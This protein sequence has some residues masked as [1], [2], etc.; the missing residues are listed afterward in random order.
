MFAVPQPV[1]AD[2]IATTTTPTVATVATTTPPV[3]LPP[4]LEKIAWCESRNNPKAKNRY[5]TASG[6]FQFLKGSWAY[7]GKKLW[8]DELVNKDV[9]DY[10]DNT[11]L[12]LYVYKRNGTSDW[13]ESKPCWS[14]TEDV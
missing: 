11:E 2:V 10:E 6:R 3:V 7:Y 14:P 8:G 12:A 9:F 4:L 5:S 1:Q 13:L